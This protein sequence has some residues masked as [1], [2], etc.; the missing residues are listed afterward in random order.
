AF[1]AA[2]W[3]PAVAQPTQF[4]IS[5]LSS[6]PDTVSGGDTFAQVG[7]PAS[8]P[9]SDVFVHLNGQDVTGAFRSIDASTLQGVVTGLQ[10]GPN[11][12]IAGQ[13][14]SGQILS[15]I[16]V[17]NHRI[18]GPVFSGHQQTPFIC[19]TDSFVLPTTG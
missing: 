4:Q 13:R 10:V 12:L 3:A 18:A 7:V 8:T 16:L 9:L 14:S 6:R 1:S 15:K 2:V 5:I 17:T 11:V 19:Q